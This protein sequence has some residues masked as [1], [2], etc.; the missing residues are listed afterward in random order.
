MRVSSNELQANTMVKKK[1]VDPTFLCSFLLIANYGDSV[2]NPNTLHLPRTTLKTAVM[3]QHFKIQSIFNK[4]KKYPKLIETALL[5]S[6][7]C[8]ILNDTAK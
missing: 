1:K 7:Q 4:K 2:L 6:F 3:S 5:L 8:I